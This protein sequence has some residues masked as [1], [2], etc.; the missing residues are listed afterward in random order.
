MISDSIFYKLMRKLYSQSKRSKTEIT[1]IETTI[2]SDNVLE[3]S[4]ADEDMIINIKI[5]TSIG[6]SNIRHDIKSSNVIYQTK[7][8]FYS[9]STILA[10]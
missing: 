2:S 9:S 10:K 6:Y 1:N 8:N 5:N 7:I 3:Y 4:V